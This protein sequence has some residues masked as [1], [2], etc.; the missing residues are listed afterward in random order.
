VNVGDIYIGDGAVVTHLAVIP[1]GPVIAAARIS[2]TIVDTAVKTNMR[3]PVTGM[4]DIDVPLVAPIR[5]RPESIHPGCHYPN[6]GNPIVARVRIAP[7]TRCPD[8]VVSG[9]FGLIVIGKRRRGV[10]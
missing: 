4:P 2:K 6:A 5:R 8:I 10:A 7:I 3:T 9:T 1:I